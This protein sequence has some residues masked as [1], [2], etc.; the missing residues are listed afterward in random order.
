ME[1][2]MFFVWLTVGTF[3]LTSI[4]QLLFPVR[5]YE[6]A[7]ASDMSTA[8]KGRFAYTVQSLYE[9]K[10]NG[11]DADGKYWWHITWFNTAISLGVSTLVLFGAIIITVILVI[12]V[13]FLVLAALAN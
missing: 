9:I 12:I 7:K 10:T 11:F 5:V 2:G 13:G 4:I 1:D 8:E 6:K 3:F